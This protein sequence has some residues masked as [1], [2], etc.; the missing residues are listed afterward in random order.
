MRAEDIL[1]EGFNLFK[2]NYVAFIIATLIAAFGSIFI[3]TIPPL[4]FGIYVMASKATRGEDVEIADVFKGFDYFFVSWVMFIVGGIAI[5]FGLI[6]FVIPG[7]LLMILFQYAIPIAISERE[8]G[9]DALKKSYNIGKANLE[10]TI[11]LGIILWVFN[12]IGS[13]LTVGWLITAPFVIIC[14]TIATQ[15]LTA[16]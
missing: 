1:S 11:I 12:A 13:S 5:L 10:F 2:K 6:F 15:K 8:S 16:E 14:L 3:I 7:L 9:V 4:W